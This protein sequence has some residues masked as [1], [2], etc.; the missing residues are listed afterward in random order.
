MT[1]NLFKWLGIKFGWY[2]TPLFEEESSENVKKRVIES[3]KRPFI[4]NTTA[5]KRHVE[6]LRQRA[7]KHHDKQ[8]PG[9]LYVKDEGKILFNCKS[10][11]LP[12][13]DNEK[14]ISC[15]PK[16]IY[17]A[18]KHFSPRFKTEVILLKNV[19]NRDAI[20]IHP[21][22]FVRQLRGCIAVGDNF[23][24]IDS[25]GLK[26]VTNSREVFKNLLL[27]LPNKFKIIIN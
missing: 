8:T 24:D 16:G 7:Y 26:D 10:L 2:S 23:I 17:N 6:I 27:L 13:K 3:T 25:D 4:P 20:E 14:N 9:A 1:F 15:I 21:A 11:E 5:G 22:N 18:E 19:P 12:W